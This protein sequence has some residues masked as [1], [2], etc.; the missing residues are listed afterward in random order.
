MKAALKVVLTST[1][2]A[3]LFSAATCGNEV[4]CKQQKV[5]KVPHL[6]ISLINQAGEPVPDANL[7]VSNEAKKIA[8]GRTDKDGKLSFDGLK[9]G[10]YIV[11]IRANGYQENEFQIVINNPSAKC[12]RAVQVMLSVGGPQCRGMVKLVKP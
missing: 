12:D 6:C 1:A 3:F 5:K 9:K 2:V 11:S 8:E 7:I 4:I 10:N